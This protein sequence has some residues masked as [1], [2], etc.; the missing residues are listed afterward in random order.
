LTFL[1]HR[2]RPSVGP[3]EAPVV[4]WA[5]IPARQR[6]QRLAEGADLGHRVGEAAGDRLVQHD[7]GVGDPER[8]A[9]LDVVPLEN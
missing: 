7:A 9:Q 1:T 8:L 4:W 2:F 6:F 5:R 3:F